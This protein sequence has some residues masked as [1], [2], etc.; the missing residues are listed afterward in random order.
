MPPGWPTAEAFLAVTGIPVQLVRAAAIGGAAL[1][2]WAYAISLDTRAGWSGKRWRFFWLAAATL[3]SSSPGRWVFT[4]Q[5]GRRHDRELATDAEADAA[6]V[7]DHLVMEMEATSDAART[8]ERFLS[9]FG[10]A[11]DLAGADRPGSTTSSMRWPGQGTSTSPTCSTRGHDGGGIQPRPSRQL[12]GE[13][14]RR[15]PVLPG[16]DGRGSGR[17]IGVGLTSGKAGFYASEPVRDPAGRWS[18][19]RS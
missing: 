14:L 18:A 11:G 13:E 10:L 8:A 5:L 17:F 9:S 3:A 15:A 2:I 1:G 6:Q 7:Q 4:D 19:S 16:R 12:P